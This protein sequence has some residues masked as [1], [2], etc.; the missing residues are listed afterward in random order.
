M[1]T[2]LFFSLFLLFAN[3]IQAITIEEIRQIP[4]AE[5]HLH[6]G[7]SYPL[8]YLKTIATPDEFN[9]LQQ[10]IHQFVDGVDYNQCFFVFSLI[11]KIINTPERLEDGVY[12]LCKELQADGVTYV[13]IR[14]G[15][16]DLGSGYAGYL[17]AVLNGIRKASQDN[18]KANILLSLKRNSNI[19]LAQLTVDLALQYKNDGVVGIDISDN[20]LQGDINTI[21]PVLVNGK[22]QGL[23]FVIHMGESPL[24]KDQILLLENLE[25]VR[26]GH[27]VHLKPESLEWIKS[28]KIPIEIC[29]SSSVCAKMISNRSEHPGL[30]L[31][32]EG[33]PVAICTDDPLIFRTSLS[34][35]YFDFAKEMDCSFAELKKII[36][37]CHLYKIQQ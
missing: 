37:E 10:G 25:P 1:K 12:Y 3:H 32:A 2:I 13:E 28:R 26:I 11:N 20:S 4:K 7:G 31:Y 22:E 36:E 17:K 9:A 33:H 21:L 15:L 23:S 34:Q 14:T 29:L 5:L 6:L 18:F 8:P 16:K 27:G 35:E 30:Q 19:E 24:E